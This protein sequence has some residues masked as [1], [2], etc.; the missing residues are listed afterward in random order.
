M[1][2]NTIL[3]FGNNY[4]KDLNEAYNLLQHGSAQDQ[5]KAQMIIDQVNEQ[6]TM[7]SNFEK[8]RHEL[9]TAVTNNIGH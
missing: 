7:Q 3:P 4:D 8:A 2:D 1:A 6:I 5:V 9:M